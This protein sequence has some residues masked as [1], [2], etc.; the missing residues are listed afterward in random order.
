[1][2]KKTFRAIMVACLLAPSTMTIAQ[3]NEDSNEPA[4]S[5]EDVMSAPFASAPV[6]AKNADRFAWV[7]NDKGVRN[8]FTSVGPNYRTQQLT[9][10]SDD[11]GQAIGGLSLSSDGSMILYVRGGAPNRF[12]ELPNPTSNPD[13]V[14]REI[15]MIN[16]YGGEPR[17]IAEGSNPSFMPGDRSVLFRHR[18]A[19]HTVSLDD[20][21]GPKKLFSMRGSV[22]NWTWSPDMTKL[23]FVSNRGTHSFVGVYTPASN[24]LKWM[25]PS[26]EQ[27][28][29]PA[30]SPDGSKLAFIRL[31]GLPFGK[32]PYLMEATK[33]D[34]MVANVESGNAERWFSA[35]RAHGY[36]AIN[37]GLPL[38]WSADNE[39]VFQS[40][41]KGY[42]RF[43]K[44]QYPGEEPA[45]LMVGRCEI[46]TAN[47]SHDGRDILVSNNCSDIQRRDVWRINI[48]TGQRTNLTET[49]MA[50]ESDP[51]SS[52]SG[53]TI[54]YRYGD[55][56]TPQQVYL[57]DGDGRNKRPARDN[58][59]SANFPKDKL[60]TPSVVTLTA[61]DGM[62]TYGTLFKPEGASSS[63]KRP[64]L[65]F[66]HGGPVRQMMPAFHNRG[67]YA[68][69]YA[70]N[71]YLA[72]KGY[73]VLALNF[74]AGIGY[75]R[76]F[77][78]FPTQGPRGASEHLDMVA[79]G[80]Y[81]KE[82]DYVDGD[83]IG[84]WG[85]S[86][87]GT[88][89]GM[90]LARNPEL[91][92]TGVAFHGVFDWSARS[93]NLRGV[94]GAAGWNIIGEEAH[95]LAKQSSTVGD[96]SKWQAP[97]LF[98]HGDDDRNVVF[99]QSIDLTRRLEEKGITV[100]NLVF[101]DE[102]HSFLVHKNWVRAFDATARWF[103]RYLK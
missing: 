28:T 39:L 67:Y 91:F 88:M 29:L 86:Y 100:E 66:L 43:Y 49:D 26:I 34:L 32:K 87:G 51:I 98:I 53:Q 60:Q 38:F 79:A 68:N 17:K 14:K 54:A 40:E 101:P 6:T 64:A 72:A 21:S 65:I 94:E 22:S 81:L 84:L 27:D 41:H 47:V 50:I 37:N 19:L 102:V 46:E 33:F 1:M 11:D 16:T 45:A 2:I 42:L 96:L 69:T 52:P 83:K 99:Q 55:A 57:M 76:D 20:D 93:F 36:F 75:G 12:G 35:D 78:T 63:D 56:S 25:A 10:Y 85:G 95:A 59:L 77:R 92:K 71:Q 4:F 97:V 18:G 62:R 24:T 61:L 73:V 13:G 9:S 74:R 70:M 31:P 82:L 48:R 90:G 80:E 8:I 3:I 44:M 30:W 58:V 103:D 15:W 5:L 23:A 89:T 7:V